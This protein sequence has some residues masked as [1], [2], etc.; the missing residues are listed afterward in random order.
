MS[1]RGTVHFHY[2]NRKASAIVYVHCDSFPSGLGKD[3]KEFFKEVAKLGDTRFDDPNYLAAKWV[4]YKAE[5][6][7]VSKN[8]LNFLGVGIVM[9]DPGDI[10]YRYH[11]HCDYHPMVTVDRI[12][13]YDRKSLEAALKEEND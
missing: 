8:R 10:E 13:Y 5:Q 9:D 7:A 1:T 3:L 12:G 2:L 11:V 6:N 4:V